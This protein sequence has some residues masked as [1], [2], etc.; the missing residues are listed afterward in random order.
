MWFHTHYH[1]FLKYRWQA[2]S[3]PASPENVENNSQKSLRKQTLWMVTQEKKS[4]HQ[5]RGQLVFFFDKW[6]LYFTLFHPP[7]HTVRTS[8]Y[9][10]EFNPYWWDY[11][12]TVL[13]SQIF[14]IHNIGNW[15]LDHHRRQQSRNNIIKSNCQ[16]L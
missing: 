12:I 3:C 9:L 5:E 4:L 14:Y 11:A 10:M 15:N 16:T 13:I 7:L 1:I 8:E 6:T 2:P